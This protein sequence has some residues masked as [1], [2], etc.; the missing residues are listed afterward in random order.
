MRGVFILWIMYKVYILYY[1]HR[2]KYYIGFIGD[3]IESSLN[4][5]NSNHK[6]FTGKTADWK[7]AH[8]EN[9]E[10]KE[11]PI[12]RELEIKRWKCSKQNDFFFNW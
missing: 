12:K 7:I 9:Y 5:L 2:N 11:H 6:G 1:D 3:D 10:E 8:L 4:K